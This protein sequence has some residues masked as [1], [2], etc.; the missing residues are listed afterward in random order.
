MDV[1]VTLPD[2]TGVCDAQGKAYKLD[3][4]HLVNIPKE[5]ARHYIEAGAAVPARKIFGGIEMPWKK[6]R[7]PVE[8]PG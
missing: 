7:P 4:S 3:N 8:K 6:V 5:L 1:Q 2:C